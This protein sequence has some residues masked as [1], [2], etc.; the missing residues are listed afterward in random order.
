M[1]TEKDALLQQI[2]T[3]AQQD[4]V[5]AFSGGVDSALLLCL[6]SQASRETGRRVYA[7]TFHTV[8]HPQ[9]DLAYAREMAGSMD[10]SHHILK[11]DELEDP[12]ILENPPDRCY[13]C[14][15]MLFEKLWGFAREKHVDTVLEGSNRDDLAVY[16]PG[17]KAVQEM[18][19][20][21]PLAQCGV[22]KA[23]VRQMAAEY[24]LPAAS[25]PSVPCL[26]TR[27]PYGTP[28]DTQLLSRID[29]GE[30]F[31]RGLGLKNV[32]IRVHGDIA[33]LETDPEDLPLLLKHRPAVVRQ[34]K[35]LDLPY[36]TLDLEGFRSG[37]MDVHLTDPIDITNGG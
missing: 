34:L 8:L 11:I 35:G 7:V 17:L 14:K 13:H 12:R 31:L 27:I 5:L 24:G 33:R 28:L 16:R 6:L 18:G 4:T 26:A 36:L 3:Y 25:R 22:T 2:R 19:V 29:Q 21:S 15:K 37:S 9:A 30:R 1:T 10:V 23:Q 20:A 32:R